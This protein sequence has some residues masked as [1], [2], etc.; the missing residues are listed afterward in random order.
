MRNCSYETEVVL[1]CTV[2]VHD[3]TA[4]SVGAAER[5]A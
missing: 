5:K 2:D 3:S 1:C 4:E